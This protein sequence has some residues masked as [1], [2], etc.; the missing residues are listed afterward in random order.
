MGFEPVEGRMVSGNAPIRTSN[1]NALS[2]SAGV[3]VKGA[4]QTVPVKIPAAALD[5][6]FGNG[7]LAEN[8]RGDKRRASKKLNSPC[9]THQR[10]R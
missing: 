10:L 7:D 2:Q 8:R 9:Q 5:G 4:G 3:D 6:T 1:M